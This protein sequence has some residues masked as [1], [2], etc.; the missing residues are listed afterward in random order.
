MTKAL[1]LA[2][3][4]LGA[5]ETT[6][7]QTTPL[8][9]AIGCAAMSC[10]PDEVCVEYTAGIDAGPGG[11]VTNECFAVPEGCYIFNCSGVRC[12]PCIQALCPS[13][14]VEVNGRNVYCAAP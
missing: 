4:V 14:P 12:A 8:D 10:G 9:G 5:C 1:L 7:Y 3:A 13:V 2:V 6:P 11:G